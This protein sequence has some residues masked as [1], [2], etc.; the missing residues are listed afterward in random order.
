MANVKTQK[1]GKFQEK[2]NYI[3]LILIDL[4]IC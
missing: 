4:R 3:K 2:H 1:A